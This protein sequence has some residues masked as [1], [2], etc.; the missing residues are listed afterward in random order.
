MGS[1]RAR[2]EISQLG[3]HLVRL[4]PL[5]PLKFAALQTAILTSS[6]PSSEE[7]VRPL[8]LSVL[9]PLRALLRSPTVRSMVSSI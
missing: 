2:E 9:T 4:S 8:G 6:Y 1:G 7:P 3:G 5:T